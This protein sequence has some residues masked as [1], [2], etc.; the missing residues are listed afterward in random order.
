MSPE[1][2]INP[3]T[4]PTEPIRHVVYMAGATDTYGNLQ[5]VKEKLTENFGPENVTIYNS[6]LFGD[7]PEKDRFKTIGEDLK[8]RIEEG[9]TTI[10]AHSLGAAEMLASFE[11]IKKTYPDFFKKEKTKANLS[12]VFISPTILKNAYDGLKYASK[13]VSL[14][15]QELGMLRYT[16]PGKTSILHGIVSLSLLPPNNETIAYEDLVTKVREASQKFSRHN[17]TI[18]EISH[19]PDDTYYAS[20]PDETLKLINEQ[21]KILK[22]TSVDTQKGIRKFRRALKKRGRLTRKI[23]KS[24]FDRTHPANSDNA[25]IEPEKAKKDKE[26]SKQ[27]RQFLYDTF[28]NGETYKRLKD[29]LKDLGDEAKIKIAVPEYDLLMKIKKAIQVMEKEKNVET[30]A[31]STHTS[32]WTLKPEVLVYLINSAHS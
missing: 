27:I 28:F 23:L 17:N 31:P 13:F 2:S 18:Y 26:A 4:L 21:D 10:L 14:G 15:V 25:N 7:R 12:I 9:P 30:V 19:K 24:I 8:R 20:I 3:E 16:L 29:L 5:K 1:I 11:K 32:P 22:N 6:A